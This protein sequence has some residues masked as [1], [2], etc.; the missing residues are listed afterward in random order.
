MFPSV[1]AREEAEAKKEAE[2]KAIEAES[3]RWHDLNNIE[4]PSCQEKKHDFGVPE[5][6]YEEDMNCAE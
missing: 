4:E 2:E 6:E 3:K 1:R 5:Y